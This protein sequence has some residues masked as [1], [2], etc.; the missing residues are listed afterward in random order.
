M[1]Y[2]PLLLGSASPRRRELIERIGVFPQAFDAADIDETPQKKEQPRA[3]TMRMGLEKNKALRTRYPEHI[4]LTSDTTVA[5]GRRILGKPTDE[6]DAKEMLG[7]MS[8]RHHDVLTSVVV[9]HPDGQMGKKL[10]I[11][12]VHFKSLTKAE[13]NAYIDSGEWEG[14]AGGYGIQGLA[15]AFVRNISGSYTGVVGLPLYET[16]QLLTGK[17]YPAL[18]KQ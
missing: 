2:P 6:Q 3:Y 8:G 7:L 9:S 18:T 17:G 14:K 11:T 12:R 16:Y 10:S 13:I 4:I 5:I 1:S 15:N